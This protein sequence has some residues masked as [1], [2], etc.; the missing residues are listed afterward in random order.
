MGG[1]V[2]FD[3]STLF[4]WVS[5]SFSLIPALFSFAVGVVLMVSMFFT[6]D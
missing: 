3:L 6:D 2:S 5:L 1:A 4:R